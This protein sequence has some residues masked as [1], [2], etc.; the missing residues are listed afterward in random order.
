MRDLRF[1]A[2]NTRRKEMEMIDDLY[3][4]KKIIV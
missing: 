1:R 3:G 4:S 2:W